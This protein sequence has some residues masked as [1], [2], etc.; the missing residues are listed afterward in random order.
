M[1]DIVSLVFF[2]FCFLDFATR[3]VPF[4]QEFDVSEKQVELRDVDNGSKL[5]LRFGA[6]ESVESMFAYSVNI[7]SLA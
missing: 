4:Y 7:Q 6:E 2:F 3:L 1:F 5:N